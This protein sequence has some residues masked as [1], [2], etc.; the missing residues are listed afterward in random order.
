T[1][2]YLSWGL[3]A[4]L[5]PAG[6]P[7]GT[8]DGRFRSIVARV[9]LVCAG[10]A[11]LSFLHPDVFDSNELYGEIPQVT[12]PI[13]FVPAA[14][15]EAVFAVGLIGL[16]AC[17]F[18]AIGSLV[19]RTIRAK[20]LE[21]QQLKIVGYTAVTT[22]VGLL[23]LANLLNVD[24]VRGTAWVTAIDVVSQVLV[25]AIPTSFAL[26]ILRYR[27]YDID[28]VINKT[29]VY[30]L[31]GLFVTTAYIAVVV[32]AGSVAGSS[33]EPS[34]PLSIGT[35]AFVA[36]GFQPARERFQQ[37][38]NRLVYG[39][40]AAPS[41]LMADLAPRMAVAIRPDD[42]LPRVAEYAARVVGAEVATVRLLLPDGSAQASSWPVG[43]AAAE[44]RAHEVDVVQAGELVGT[45]SVV[46]AADDP[47]TAGDRVR[48]QEFV[49]HVGVALSNVRLTAD[50]QDK[51]AR[52]SAQANE[53]RESR[54]RI[55]EASDAERRRIERNLHDGAQQRLV[56]LGL[57]LKMLEGRLPARSA[58]RPD[59]A[60][61]SAELREALAELRELARGIHPAVLTE[62]GLAP[63]L[64]TLV[65]RAGVDADLVTAPSERLPDQVE[66]AAYYVV[67]EA[68][69]NVSRYADATQATVAAHRQNG[70]LVVEVRD[71]GV[72]GADIAKGSGL[73][74]LADRIAA[75]DGTIEIDSPAGHGTRVT[76]RLPCA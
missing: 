42:L 69:T 5:V 17:T 46:K 4:V 61:I 20:G 54:Q 55:V 23:V 60:R 32:G 31:L 43:V 2:L 53:L 50:L 52:I 7:H 28:V 21:R 71:D 15:V 70:S 14:V 74:G 48:L 27:L 11:S 66:A 29:L 6:F 57:E 33:D 47:M 56:A 13:G 75:L 19:P 12:N 8:T 63:A 26:A 16:F 65:A 51:L 9:G 45:I 58:A 64:E 68:L 37:L 35:T 25:L 24:A 30:G 73:R 34:I 3:L 41:E 36:V 40:R 22:T 39:V 38:A 1:G 10:A 18:L 44:S 67:A 76:V 59:L 49:T 62:Q 72:G